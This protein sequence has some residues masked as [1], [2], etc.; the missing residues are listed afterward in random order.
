MP[1]KLKGKVVAINGDWNSDTD[2][3]LL[4]AEETS[5]ELHTA[6]ATLAVWRSTGRYKL[7]F[8]KIGGKVFYMF[9]HVRQFKHSRT[10][11]T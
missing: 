3:K 4:T 5:E 10:I 9:G 6:V 11:T 7:P 1:E 8:T 2:D